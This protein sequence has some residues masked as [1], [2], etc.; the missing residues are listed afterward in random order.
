MDSE[1]RPC[2]PDETLQALK[3]SVEVLLFGVSKEACGFLAPYPTAQ[4]QEA[5]WPG[6]VQS[7]LPLVG[8]LS[9]QAYVAAAANRL[10]DVVALS[11]SDIP[12]N[13]AALS[14]SILLA[15]AGARHER[16][17]SRLAEVTE[18]VHPCVALAVKAAAFNEPAV[19]AQVAY[20]FQ[21]WRA[22]GTQSASLLTFLESQ[23]AAVLTL[24]PEH[25]SDPNSPFLVA[26][27]QQPS[28]GQQDKQQH[29]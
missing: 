17:M 21:E 18:P 10:E 11:A 5:A 6:F 9:F 4:M 16:L 22:S 13:A 2:D 23:S 29:G 27:S 14:Q 3:A 8:R 1:L 12:A 28:Q 20:F 24:S 19:A 7:V 25:V 26:A 15:S